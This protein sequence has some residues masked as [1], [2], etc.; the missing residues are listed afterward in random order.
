MKPKDHDIAWP[1]LGV[2]SLAIVLS[3][4][5]AFALDA[6]WEQRQES[7][8]ERA[9]L[10][11]LQQEFT[12]NLTE[13]D[14]RVTRHDEIRDDLVSIRPMIQENIDE[15]LKLDA[16]EL[17]ALVSWTTSDIA[18]GTVERLLAS[19]ELRILSNSELR[20]LLAA[21]PSDIDDAQED[22][23]LALQ[24]IEL[25][26]TPALLGHNVLSSTYL[27]R[28]NIEEG[29]MTDQQ[30]PVQFTATPELL[31]LITVRI[32]QERSARG[33][34]RILRTHAVKILDIVDA[35]L[36]DD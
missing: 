1:R 21:W 27:V 5:L 26:L 30:L 14:N 9:L 28:E 18:K 25:V 33:S 12:Q 2:E 11:S 24:F 7:G 16:R 20:S 13:I 31:D 10:E 8:F 29:I 19:G 36:G 15:T 34:L 6:W 35:E 17:V 22:E 32:G 3:I 23:V 4:L